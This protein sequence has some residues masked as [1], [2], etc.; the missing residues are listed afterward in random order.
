VAGLSFALFTICREIRRA[1]TTR[2]ATN[3][4]CSA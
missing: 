2:I 1:G 4:S 3:Q